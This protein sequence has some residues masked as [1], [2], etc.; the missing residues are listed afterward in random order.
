MTKR[1]ITAITQDINDVNE[2]ILN[3]RRQQDSNLVASLKSQRADLKA[4]AR[5]LRRSRVTTA[6]ER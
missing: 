3:A 5:N 4:E 1:T 2:Q 6:G